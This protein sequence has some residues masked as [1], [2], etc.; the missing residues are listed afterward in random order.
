MRNNK[1]KERWTP[2]SHYIPQQKIIA[3]GD[4]HGQL[5]EVQSMDQLYL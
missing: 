1:K 4:I 5:K 2:D 3:I